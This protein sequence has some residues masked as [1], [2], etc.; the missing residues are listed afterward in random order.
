[1]LGS[2]GEEAYVDGMELDCDMEFGRLGLLCTG[3]M[4][5]GGGIMHVY[6]VN[7]DDLFVS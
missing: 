2:A 4:G 6:L 1:M 5:R 7:N 3:G